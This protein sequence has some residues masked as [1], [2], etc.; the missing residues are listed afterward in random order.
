[1]DTNLVDIVRTII[2]RIDL[3]ISVNSITGV[4][5][6]VCDTMH[7]TLGKT[8]EDE[9][10]N[11]YTV[12]EFSFNEWIEVK[13]KGHA[14]PFNSTVVVAPPILF[15]HGSPSST[16]NE[17]AKINNRT[18]AKTPF[19]WLLV[20]Y[21]YTDLPRDSSIVASYDARLFFM[22]WANVPKWKNDQHN[23]LVIKPMENLSKAFINIIEA[24]YS[25]KTLEAYT[26]TP[27]PRFGVEISDRGSDKT[28][29]HENLSG[30]DMSVTLEMFNTALCCSK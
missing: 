29:I 16:N 25:F 24:D 13:P 4:R 7:I 22:D 15:L 18:L 27:R 17:Y 12:T 5:I 30:I 21:Q 11:L 1:M 14:I 3:N 6:Y 28:I 8:V 10:G 9:Y 20:S 19:I 23:Q 2:G 26:R